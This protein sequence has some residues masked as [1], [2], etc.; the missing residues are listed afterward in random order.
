MRLNARVIHKICKVCIEILQIAGGVSWWGFVGVGSFVVGVCEGV[1]LLQ[2]QSDI[3][4]VGEG[5]YFYYKY[6]IRECCEQYWQV[7]TLRI[8]VQ[9]TEQRPD[10][11]VPAA[12]LVRSEVFYSVVLCSYSV[13]TL[14]CSVI[15]CFTLYPVTSC[16]IEFSASSS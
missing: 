4:L 13:L 10:V 5:V 8:N 2:I 3:M 9:A 12:C 11:F 15:F 14:L 16:N 6:K 1:L 7:S